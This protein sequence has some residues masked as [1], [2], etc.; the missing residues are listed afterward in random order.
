MANRLVAVQCD[1]DAA[2]TVASWPGAYAP[3]IWVS[4]SALAAATAF[5]ASQAD[6]EANKFVSSIS[7]PFKVSSGL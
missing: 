7:Q 3:A 1:G 2:Q 4:V 6:V 5:I